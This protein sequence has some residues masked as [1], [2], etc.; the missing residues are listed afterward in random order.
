MPK[1]DELTIDNKISILLKAPYGFGKTLAAASMAIDGPI[2]LAYWDKKAPIELLTF[3]KKHRPE[4]LKNIEYDVYGA[5][6]A[7]Q[8]LNKLFQLARS[9]PYYGI[10][11]DS[12][13]N[14]TSAAVNWSLGFRNPSGPKKDS[15]NPAT[16]Q[17]IPDFDEYKIETSMVTQALD[18]C[19]SL[20]CN[21]IWT[22][23]PL[24]SL[25]VEGTG[26]SMKVSKVNNIVTY[27]SKVGALVPGQ[28]TEIY[29]SE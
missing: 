2:W 6:N 15:V 26:G 18:I 14:M 17:L 9:C 5:H 24:P 1:A 8:Y 25:K 13:T 23:H 3:F 22:C 4:V 27:G 29:P 21:V 10:I 11:N 19:R 12:V 16:F 20:P 28:F 7:N